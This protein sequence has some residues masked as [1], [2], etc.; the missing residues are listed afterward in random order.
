MIVKTLGSAVTRVL[1]KYKW[2]GQERQECINGLTRALSFKRCS[3][4]MDV[5]G[6]VLEFNY[7]V[8][9]LQPS[10]DSGVPAVTFRLSIHGGGG[11]GSATSGG[12]ASRT[13]TMWAKLVLQHATGEAATGVAI[14]PPSYDDP[15]T[16]TGAYTGDTWVLHTSPL[17]LNNRDGQT[18]AASSDLASGDPSVARRDNQSSSPDDTSA[19]PPPKLESIEGGVTYTAQTA[20]QHALRRGGKAAH[21]RGLSDESMTAAFLDEVD[22]V[23]TAAL[24]GSKRSDSSEVWARRLVSLQSRIW[25]LSCGYPARVLK[26]VEEFVLGSGSSNR[27]GNGNTAISS[28]VPVVSITN[29][30]VAK[31]MEVLKKRM[32]STRSLLCLHFFVDKTDPPFRDRWAVRGGSQVSNAPGATGGGGSPV[33]TSSTTP[34]QRPGVLE[35]SRVAL[36]TSDGLAAAVE[37]RLGKVEQAKPLPPPGSVQTNMNRGNSQKMA[38][39]GHRVASPSSSSSIFGN[40]RGSGGRR[41]RLLKVLAVAI[42]SCVVGAAVYVAAQ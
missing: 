19:C 30:V 15:A 13:A 35:G 23:M 6:S 2:E 18:S 38:G 40:C 34:M 27:S 8:S 41:K 32:W 9:A 26:T 29:K 21:L 12:W 5:L 16:T 4:K 20:L 31:K 37:A 33:A 36:F 25:D 10:F 3:G 24:K 14:K 1:S 39:G 11:S 17:V 42:P 22:S 28:L 7:D